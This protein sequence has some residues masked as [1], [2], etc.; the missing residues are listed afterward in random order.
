L[1]NIFYSDSGF[2]VFMNP[3]DKLSLFAAVNSIVAGNTQP[4]FGLRWRYA[5]FKRICHWNRNYRV[6]SKVR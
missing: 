4:S 2:A 5:L 1:I 3:T 6:A